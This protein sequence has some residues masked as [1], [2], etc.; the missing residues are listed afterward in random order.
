MKSSNFKFVK[1]SFP[2]PKYGN[3]ID[4][5]YSLHRLH[6][7]NLETSNLCSIVAGESITSTEIGIGVTNLRNLIT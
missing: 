4:L 2:N 1:V 6:F 5:Y 3:K 7:Y